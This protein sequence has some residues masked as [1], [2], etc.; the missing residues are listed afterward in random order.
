MPFELYSWTP[1]DGVEVLIAHLSPLGH[2]TDERRT[3]DPLPSWVVR[4][5]GGPFD[6][7]TDHGW[8]SVHSFGR[9]DAEAA[10]ADALAHRRLMVLDRG[11]V[12]VTISTGTVYID[13][14]T[15]H[16]GPEDVQW[17]ADRSIVRLVSTYQVDI[18]IVA[19]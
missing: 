19:A 13:G 15:R 3:N 4:R 2:V 5:I 1:P 17:V 18:R 16:E 9:T 14:I 10:A 12:P 6:G 8:Y 11:P 7:L